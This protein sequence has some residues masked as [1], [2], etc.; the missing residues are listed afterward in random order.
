[1]DKNLLYEDISTFTEKFTYSYIQG[2]AEEIA[3]MFFRLQMEEERKVKDFALFFDYETNHYRIVV[4]VKDYTFSTVQSIFVSFFGFISYAGANVTASQKTAQGIRYLL[5]SLDEQG[6]GF[7]CEVEFL[8]EEAETEDEEQQAERGTTA[9]TSG[10]LPFSQREHPEIKWKFEM[11]SASYFPLLAA[12]DLIYS[13]G[14]EGDLYAVDARQGSLR[15]H[16]QAE[17]QQSKIATFP[18]VDQGV[19]AVYTSARSQFGLSEA[20]LWALDA[21]TGQLLRSS[22]VPV[23]QSIGSCHLLTTRDGVAYLSGTDRNLLPS[24]PHSLC[25]ALDLQTGMQKWRVDGGR[26]LGTTTPVVAN[27]HLYLV[28][29]DIQFGSP[30]IGYLHA[31]DIQTGEENWNYRFETRGIQEIVVDGTEIFVAGTRVEVVDALTG[32]TKWNLPDLDVFRDHPFVV[33]DEF[34][35]ISYEYIS[36]RK[37]KLDAKRTQ[38]VL[39][40][41]GPPR[42]GKFIAIERASKQPRWAVNLIHGRSLPEK[43][44]LADSMLY[45]TWKHLDMR[46]EIIHATLFALDARTGQERWRFEADNLSAPLVVAGT[47]FIRGQEDQK[48]YIY[49]LSL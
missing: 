2:I 46:G 22:P 29:F 34:I 26:H 8:P 17:Q 12:Q 16:W 9:Q 25:L 40:A 39:L 30:F 1:M 24:S 19:L 10:I 35:Y 27:G 33:S 32:M 15:W 49:A 20:T 42:T 31:L 18:S 3:E 37:R 5:A 44:V 21:Q 23:L 36:A 7:Y 28:T 45:T 47:V 14:D 43:P 48:E 11:G 13:V 38:E 41:G 4:V 6:K